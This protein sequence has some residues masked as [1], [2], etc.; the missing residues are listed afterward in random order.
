MQ[1]LHLS[2]EVAGW[3][4]MPPNCAVLCVQKRQGELA[5]QVSMLEELDKGFS[6]IG[7]QS[8][9]LEGI[10]GELQ[11]DTSGHFASVHSMYGICCTNAGKIVIF[12]GCSPMPL[13]QAAI[14]SVTSHTCFGQEFSSRPSHFSVK[15]FKGG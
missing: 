10:L 11:V 8:F 7:V 6:R 12:P 5:G 15:A 1:Q 9:A 2:A 14:G 3:R 13:L 4:C